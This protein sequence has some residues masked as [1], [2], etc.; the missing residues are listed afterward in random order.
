M[1][2]T[3]VLRLHRLQP[4]PGLE[5]LVIKASVA[6]SVR[7]FDC[8]NPSHVRVV[9]SLPVSLGYRLAWLKYNPSLRACRGF[10]VAFI[11]GL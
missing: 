7:E 4:Q 1:F 9:A 5:I 2:G 11:A 3:I 6:V 10:F 8:H